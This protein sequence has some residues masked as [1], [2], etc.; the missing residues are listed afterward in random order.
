MKNFIKYLLILSIFIF[1]TS[2]N[3]IA[4]NDLPFD[5]G[6][7][8]NRENLFWGGLTLSVAIGTFL[9]YRYWY[10]QPEDNSTI[11]EMNERPTLMQTSEKV[12]EEVKEE[13]K[14]S[15][16]ESDDFDDSKISTIVEIN[17]IPTL[18]QTP[19]KVNGEVKEEATLSWNG[20]NNFDDIN[21]LNQTGNWSNCSSR[22]SSQ[23]S[24]ATQTPQKPDPEEG[25]PIPSEELIILL[26]SL[27]STN[28]NHDTDEERD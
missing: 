3:S 7:E 21:F 14:L 19:E 15:W 4:G 11:V 20:N 27:K 17:E 9:L 1:S 10:Q 5:D 8:I 25:A 18:M 22:S 26:K 24:S 28:S 13:A 2:R 16:K 6:F 23:N 12:N